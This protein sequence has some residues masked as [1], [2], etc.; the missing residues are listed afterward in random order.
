MKRYIS[1]I[2]CLFALLSVSAQSFEFLNFVNDDATIKQQTTD[3]LVIK[4]VDG[5]AVAAV[6]TDT[7]TVAMKDL[8]CMVF[9]DIQQANASYKKGD[10]DGNDF[11]DVDDL[12]ILINIILKKD[13]AANYEG[14]AY[15]TGQQ[16]VDVAD[17]NAVVNIIL[18]KDPEQ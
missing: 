10:V 14:R 6:G 4:F 8:S 12:N 13:S 15:V 5:K 2:L 11:V 9:T 1:T 18:K 16:T 3:G 17:I 7:L